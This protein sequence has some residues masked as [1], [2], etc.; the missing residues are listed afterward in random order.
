MPW[1]GTRGPNIGH[2]KKCYTAFSFMLYYIRDLTSIW[3]GLLCNEVKVIVTYIA[4]L[5][6]FAQY[7]EDYLMD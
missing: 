7:L 3:P 1:D 2:L 5:S 4:W 6:G